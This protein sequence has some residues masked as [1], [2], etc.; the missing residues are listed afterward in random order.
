[1]NFPFYNY[2]MVIVLSSDS[3]L[4]SNSISLEVTTPFAEA[5]WTVGILLGRASVFTVLLII[6]LVIGGICPGCWAFWPSA[7]LIASRYFI[8]NQLRTVMQR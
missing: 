5:V 8:A 4:Y 1:M 6:R 7:Y 2:K 3:S